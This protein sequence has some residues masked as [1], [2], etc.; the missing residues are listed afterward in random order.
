MAQADSSC[1]W[2][3]LPTFPNLSYRIH[4]QCGRG[5]L[6]GKNEWLI[7]RVTHHLSLP[8]QAGQG[9][10]QRSLPVLLPLCSHSL[11]RQ[12][13]QVIPGEQCGR[14]GASWSCP[15]GGWRSPELVVE[16]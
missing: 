9:E 15:G 4:P 12:V 8:L 7:R 2:D 13:G 1:G 11:P 10:P 16:A 6:G 14:K 5:Q 3:P